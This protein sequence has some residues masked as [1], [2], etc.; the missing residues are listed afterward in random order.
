[1]VSQATAILEISATGDDAP[2][3]DETFT[4]ILDTPDGGAELGPRSQR[5]LV[6]ERNDAPYGLL[7]IYPAETRYVVT[8][9]L[10]GHYTVTLVQK[11]RVCH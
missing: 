7:Q 9:V 2:E 3:E 6:V 4:V 1:M 5:T 10:K 11:G 8:S